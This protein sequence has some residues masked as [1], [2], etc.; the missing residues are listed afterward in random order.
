MSETTFTAKMKSAFLWILKLLWKILKAIIGIMVKF[1]ELMMATSDSW[2]QRGGYYEDSSGSNSALFSKDSNH[3]KL[4]LFLATFVIKA[5]GKVQ[6]EELVYIRKKMAKEFSSIAVQSWMLRLEKY[7]EHDLNFEKLCKKAAYLFNQSTK[8]QLLHFL[9]G[10][11]TKD[12][13][14]TN[15]ELK[16][17]RKISMRI[18]IPNRTLMSILALYNYITEEQAKQNRERKSRPKNSSQW[19]LKRAFTILEL[20]ESATD[21]EIK[22]AY[23]KL[24]KIHH[25]D[26]VI[27][28]GP[29]F[30]KGAERKFKQ[31]S[32]AYEAIKEKRGFA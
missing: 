4:S 8:I 21:K 9:A 2:D 17:L 20:N 19:T 16:I 28:M 26:A 15:A 22:K 12:S 7:L 14:L 13:M 23:R 5:D 1:I 32:E 31:I 18:G 6:T 3:I 27:H 25:P 11:A 24:A 30:Q 29:E 10:I